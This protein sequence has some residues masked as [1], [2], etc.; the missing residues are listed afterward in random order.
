M[1]KKR[2]MD[3]QGSQNDNKYIFKWIKMLSYTSLLLQNRFGKTGIKN[4]EKNLA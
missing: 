3:I 4:Q 1:E 2:V